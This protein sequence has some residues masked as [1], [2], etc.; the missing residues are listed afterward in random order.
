MR[1]SAATPGWAARGT[2]LRT[3]VVRW[4]R[5]RCQR[6]PVKT[7]AIATA[8]DGNGN[9]IEVAETYTGPPGEES[10]VTRLAYDEFDRPL[11]KTD[12]RGERI[13]YG[14]DAVGNR[15]RLT[16][17]D[18][19]T[20]VY[21]Y[22]ALDRLTSVTLPPSG[23]EAGGVVEQRYL[24]N[25]LLKEVLYPNGASST[26]AYDSANRLLSIDHRQHAAPV[27][28]YVYTYDRNGNRLVQEETNGGVTEST[29]YLYDGADRL[30]SVRYPDRS[31]TYT[32]DGVGN[33]ATET[34]TDPGGAP[35]LSARTYTYDAR[36]RLIGRT[37]SVDPSNDVHWAYDANGNQI[38][39]T[40]SG[41]T[42]GYVYDVRDQ[43]VE[44]T[45]GGS[46]LESYAYA[47]DGLRTRKSGPGGLFR[48]VY[49]Q[50]SLLLETDLSGTTVSK[51]EWGSDRLLALDHATEGRQL[52][53]VDALG[54]PIALSKPDGTLQTRLQWDAWGNER[55]EVGESA[56]RFGFTGYQR[57][58]A[59]GLYYA[60]ARLYDPEVGRFL[61][62]DPFEGEAMTPP[63]LH[64]YAYAHGRPT[65]FVDPTGREAMN[66]L[67]SE[68]DIPYGPEKDFYDDLEAE[69]R[70]RTSAAV[71]GAENEESLF[72]IAIDYL[73][74]LLRTDDAAA[75]FSSSIDRAIDEKRTT[76][77]VLAGSDNQ[78]P[79][80]AAQAV[81]EEG[82]KLAGAVVEDAF[83]IEG[84]LSGVK[85]TASLGS[86]T[87][88]GARRISE[89]GTLLDLHASRSGTGPRR[90]H[91]VAS[92]DLP[93][94]KSFSGRVFRLE[95]P[96]RLR[97]TWDV[98]AGNVASDH[99][100]SGRGVG[101]TYGSLTEETARA[102]V[103]KWGLESGRVSIWR[104][105]KAENILDLTDPSVRR[106][107]GVTLDDLTH[108][109][110]YSV[111][112]RVGNWARQS[113]FEGL[114]VPS[115]P[116]RSG[117]NLV[118]FGGSK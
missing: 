12:P 32:L 24:R 45:R 1:K 111:T 20:T 66:G 110:D 36:D 103:A 42:T 58:E 62:E 88:F 61:S 56:N 10:R 43:L 72:R 30:V 47:W 52:Y 17:P 90:W 8:Y 112:Q 31:V 84:A 67:D 41:E 40:A 35:I 9:P 83:K 37:D 94:G 117:Q 53:L 19:K 64:R 87:R 101:A 59:T 60:Q 71:S 63:S 23:T 39:K 2:L 73:R 44:V 25:S 93:T 21:G 28:S 108:P 26:Y 105:V 95:E 118:L 75:N 54:S 81:V 33:R 109:T 48:Y 22:D 113:G 3:L 29:S 65:V 104:S 91:S 68:N 50:R 89:R 13:I 51:I 57:D 106:Q 6:E 99:R 96:S 98:H 18:G 74:R 11:S 49:D 79:L 76:D 14:Y 116:D 77:D 7:E 46:L 5:Q 115:S 78:K 38:E 34:V 97:T 27:A 16:D 102:E 85:V 86:L 70:A 80:R 4:M 55:K 69:V 114:L 100:Y 92:E 15:T 82:Q 107:L